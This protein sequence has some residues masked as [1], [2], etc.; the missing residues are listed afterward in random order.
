[1]ADTGIGIPRGELERVFDRF[2]QVDSSTSRP[3]GG[4]GMGLAVAKEIVE[5]HGGRIWAESRP[6]EGSKFYFT[7]PAKRS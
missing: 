2:Y 4:M 3:Y 1:V 7:L 5:A 6:G